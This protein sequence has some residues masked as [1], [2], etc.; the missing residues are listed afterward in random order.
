MD[1]D[2]DDGDAVVILIRHLGSLLSNVNSSDEN[3]PIIPLHTSFRDFLVE[4]LCVVCAHACNTSVSG[5]DLVACP[6]WDALV[7]CR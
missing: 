6:S 3:F 1:D 7:A 4:I 2:D 5:T